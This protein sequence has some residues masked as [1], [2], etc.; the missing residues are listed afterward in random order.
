VHDREYGPLRRKERPETDDYSRR[1]LD[2]YPVPFCLFTTRTPKFNKLYCAFFGS[3]YGTVQRTLLLLRSL[4]EQDCRIT[5][6]KK[7]RR[8]RWISAKRNQRVFFQQCYFWENLKK[9]H[10][11]KCVMTFK[12]FPSNSMFSPFCTISS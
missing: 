6:T 2:V 9:E 8:K 7:R 12:M 10:R 1:L 11:D 3:S 5:T 4:C